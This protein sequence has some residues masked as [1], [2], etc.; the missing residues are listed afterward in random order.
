MTSDLTFKNSVGGFKRFDAGIQ[1]GGGYSFR[2]SQKIV[3][4]DLRY[5]YGM[6]NISYDKEVYNRNM[7]ISLHF[8]K[9]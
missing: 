3:T 1:M 6:T 4:V 9:A 5:C 7:L 2:V 8:S